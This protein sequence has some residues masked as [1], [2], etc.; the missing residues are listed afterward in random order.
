[1]TVDACDDSSE[2]E[3]HAARIPASDLGPAR[4]PPA[5]DEGLSH[6]DH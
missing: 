2:N 1:M 6:G 3:R 5:L 4:L